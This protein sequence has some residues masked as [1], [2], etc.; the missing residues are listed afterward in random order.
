MP[1]S[2]PHINGYHP[3]TNGVTERLNRTLGDMLTMYIDS[4]HSNWDA[5][6]PFVTYAYNTATQSTTGFSPFFLLYGREPC[7]TLDTIL[8]YNPDA[9]EFSPVSEMA[10]YAEE[11]RQLARPFT[12]DTQARQKVRHD[13]DVAPDTFPVGSLVWLRLPF[14]SPGLTPK[15]APKYT[16]P[17]RVIKCPSP[18]TYV[19]EPVQPSTDK[20]RLSREMVHVSRLKPYN[21][22]PV[23]S[24]P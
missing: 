16:G 9:S 5:I 1:Y 24:S 2:T 7:S 18:V 15:F 22:P 13:R 8:P 14:H 17:Y 23:L 11:C 3:Q 6:L 19:I 10:E 20:R 12:A 4:D 21:D